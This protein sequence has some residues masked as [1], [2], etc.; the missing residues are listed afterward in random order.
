MDEQET[1]I[2][3][4]NDNDYLLKNFIND[5]AQMKEIK[6]NIQNIT[7]EIQECKNPEL[8]IREKLISK[9]LAKFLN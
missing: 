8:M 2:S 5:D 7:V 9:Y 6:Q 3:Y 1:V 4:L